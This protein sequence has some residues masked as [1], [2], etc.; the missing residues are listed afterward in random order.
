[1]KTKSNKDQNKSPLELQK[2]DTMHTLQWYLEVGFQYGTMTKTDA[3]RIAR[4]NPATFYRWL[5]GKATAPAATLE[6]IRLHA[7]GEPP[8]GRSAAWRGF[9]FQ[10][11]QILT[12]DGRTLT[13]QDLKAV[14]FWRQIAFDRLD[15]HAR[16]EIYTELKAIYRQA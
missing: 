14:F 1:M 16:R 13:P 15:A 12:E 10:N 11:D 5:T 8:S 6:L 9:R 2:R 7:F 3:L 4:V